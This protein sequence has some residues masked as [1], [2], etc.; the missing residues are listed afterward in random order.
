MLND[1]KLHVTYNAI[2]AGA[3]PHP[4]V[5]AG[6]FRRGQPAWT[7]LFFEYSGMLRERSE[8]Q[9]PHETGR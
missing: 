8:P 2:Q 1:D 7:E 5:P 6:A 3:Q 4:E 9:R